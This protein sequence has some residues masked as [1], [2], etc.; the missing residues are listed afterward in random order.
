MGCYKIEASKEEQMNSNTIQTPAERKGLTKSPLLHPRDNTLETCRIELNWTLLW[1]L[2]WNI[3]LPSKRIGR[4]S[5]PEDLTSYSSTSSRETPGDGSISSW[6]KLRILHRWMDQGRELIESILSEGKRS[7]LAGFSDPGVYL[8]VTALCL[9]LRWNKKASGVPGG[10]W[11][12]WLTDPRWR[13]DRLPI[14]RRLDGDQ[15]GGAICHRTEQDESPLKIAY[16]EITSEQKLALCSANP[17]LSAFRSGELTS[18]GSVEV[19]ACDE[20]K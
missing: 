15:S 11:V 17:D 19:M 10:W 9:L 4:Y 1:K 13:L 12:R 8:R 2:W 14:Q 7:Y 3:R 16:N 20:L 5:A 18:A 6:A